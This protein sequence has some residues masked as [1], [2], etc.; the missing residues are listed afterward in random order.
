MITAYV[1][2][3]DLSKDLSQFS[4]EN[5]TSAQEN[6]MLHPQLDQL[7]FT[8]HDVRT[9]ATIGPWVVACSLDVSSTIASDSL[10]PEPFDSPPD[11]S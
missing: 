6:A 11:T 10:R 7:M 8:L 9:R 2:I 4:L 1:V 3:M 5:L